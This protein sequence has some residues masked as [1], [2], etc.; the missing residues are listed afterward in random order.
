MIPWFLWNGRDSRQMGLVIS[1]PPRLIPAERVESITVPGRPGALLRTEGEGV[2]DPYVLTVRAGNRGDANLQAIL[3]WLRG[4]GEL[5][6]STEPN[7]VYQARIINAGQLDRL[8]DGV[9]QGDI[10]FLCQPLR[11]QYPPE[12]AVSVTPS[13]TVT[14]LTVYNPGDVPARAAYTATGIG[15]VIIALDAVNAFE[16]VFP[17]SPGGTVIVDSDAGQ[18][19]LDGTPAENYANHVS[20]SYR[21]LWIPTGSHTFSWSGTGTLSALSLQPGW[22]WV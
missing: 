11:G 8:F 6:F 4:S 12:A 10:Q 16:I 19:L 20:G 18:A 15:D 22:R 14:S 5:V 3:S 9:M 21:A 2:Y 17:D 1:T 13:S 7:R